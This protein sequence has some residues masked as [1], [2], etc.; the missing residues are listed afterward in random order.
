MHSEYF[1]LCIIRASYLEAIVVEAQVDFHSILHSPPPRRAGCSST[2]N[3]SARSLL[4]PK[5][6]IGIPYLDNQG[7]FSRPLLHN[8]TSWT[9][10]RLA[11]RRGLDI[12]S[13]RGWPLAFKLQDLVFNS[14]RQAVSSNSPN[15]DTEIPNRGNERV[16]STGAALCGGLRPSRAWVFSGEE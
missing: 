8:S 1:L 6:V 7:V 10:A 15:G 12:I 4:T 3:Y 16:S 14:T 9:S 13:R 11:S 5:E 2:T